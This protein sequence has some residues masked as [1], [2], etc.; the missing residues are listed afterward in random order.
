MCTSKIE[1][2]IL[3]LVPDSTSRISTIL[4]SAGLTIW[5]SPEGIILSGLRKKKPVKAVKKSRAT[6][7]HSAPHINATEAPTPPK[8]R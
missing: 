4:P 7:A 8:I 1:R 2:K 3:S 6:A 5:S